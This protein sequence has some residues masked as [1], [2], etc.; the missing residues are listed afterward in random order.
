MIVAQMAFK[1]VLNILKSSI[2]SNRDFN[3]IGFSTLVVGLVTG[4]ISQS[5]LFEPVHAFV[6]WA[7]MAVCYNSTQISGLS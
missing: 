5:V 2:G 4:V 7:L 6:F 3:S 1:F